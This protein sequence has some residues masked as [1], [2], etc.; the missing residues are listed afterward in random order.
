MSF[1]EDLESKLEEYKLL[2]HEA[3]IKGDKERVD[4]LQEEMKYLEEARHSTA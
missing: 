4:E 2:I 3:H 1:K